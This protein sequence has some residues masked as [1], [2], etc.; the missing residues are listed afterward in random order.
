MSEIIREP[1][2]EATKFFK[3]QIDKNARCIHEF[4]K[5]VSASQWSLSA[6]VKYIAELETGLNF[7]QLFKVFAKSLDQIHVL[8]VVPVCVRTFAQTYLEW[9]GTCTGKAIVNECR[10]YFFAKV[11]LQEKTEL[12]DVFKDTVNVTAQ[13]EAYRAYIT[14]PAVPTKSSTSFS[15]DQLSEYHT[16]QTDG[17]YT[18]DESDRGTDEDVQ[19]RHNDKVDEELIEASIEKK[20]KDEDDVTSTPPTKRSYSRYESPSLTT[21]PHLQHEQT[22]QA[23]IPERHIITLEN[24]EEKENY[25]YDTFPVHIHKR[26]EPNPFLVGNQND[27]NIDEEGDEFNANLTIVGGKSTDWIISGINI[28]EK[29]TNY[30]LAVNPP[31]THPEYYDIIFFNLNDEDGFLRTLDKGIVAQMRKEI[32]MAEVDSKNQEIKLFMKNIIDRDIKKT[33]ENLNHRNA[34]TIDSFEKRFTL[35]FV[36]HMVKVMEDVNLFHD[37][38]SEGTYIVK[39][40][41]P[42]LDYFFDKKKKD[43]RVSYG[44]TCLK[45]CAKDVNSSKKDDECRSSGKKIDTIICMREE[46][47]EFSVTEV[48]GP[49]LKND[50]THF[51]GDRMKIMKMLKTLMNQFAKLNPSSDITLIRLF[52]LQAYLNELTIYEFKL[53]YT[54]VYTTEAILTF[55]LPKTWADMVN[56]DKAIMGLLKYE[57][58]LSESSKTIRDFLWAGDDMIEAIKMTTRMIHTPESTEKAKNIKSTKKMKKN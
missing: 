11:T 47:K 18:G 13:A 21:D 30:Q 42:I 3:Y 34:E 38:M 16:Q 25:L 4:F 58:L 37:P 6:F 55:P 9:L 50:W 41:A 26:P 43:W 31:K 7:E 44:E 2:L 53:K 52:G 10:E 15:E 57:H 27:H 32:K 14:A 22:Q 49:P 8:L 17:T 39:V 24:E 12:K 56:A 5:S 28:R 33:K 40:L 35:H 19:E 23:H 54:E 45:A 51:M 29:L 48:S 20:R 36:S 1:R 46:D